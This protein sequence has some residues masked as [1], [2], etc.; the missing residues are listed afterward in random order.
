MQGGTLCI[1][2]GMKNVEEF[3]T[4]LDYTPTFPREGTGEG[5]PRFATFMVPAS[6]RILLQLSRDRLAAYAS[7]IDFLETGAAPVMQSDMEELCRL[8]P[9]TRLYNTYASTETG[10]IT[11]YN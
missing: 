10:I 3:F 7:K 11:T 9:N 5:F 4:A 2:S 8:L 1:T 6:I